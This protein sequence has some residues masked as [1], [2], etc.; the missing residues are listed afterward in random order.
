MAPDHDVTLDAPAA[1]Y[2]GTPPTAAAKRLSQVILD[3]RPGALIVFASSS[4][5][6][7]CMD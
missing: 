1:V 6:D 4:V 2:V 7:D 3:I 5:R